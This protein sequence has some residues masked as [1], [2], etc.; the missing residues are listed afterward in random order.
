MKQNRTFTF[1]DFRTV[2]SYAPLYRLQHLKYTLRK[3]FGKK[4]IYAFEQFVNA[5]PIRQGL[6][7]HCPQN[8]YPLLREFVDRRFNCKRRLDA[9]TADFLMA[10]KLFGTDILHQMEDYRFH[11]VLAHLSDG[12][13]LWLNRNDNCVE[14]GAWSLSL[15]DE[16]GNRLYM[17][18]FAFV[19][20]HLLT[21]SVQGP[22]GEEAK[23]T[24]RRITKQLHGLRPQQLMVTALQYFAAV[25]GLDGAMGIAQKHQVKLRWKLKKRV[26]MNYDAFWQEYG[27]SLERDGYWHLPQTPARKDLAD[28]ESKKRSMYRKRYEMLDNMVA[29]MK[30]SLKTEARGISDGIQT[31]KPPRRTA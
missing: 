8:A 7:L 27:S 12:I 9:M 19:G 14:E 22:A 11:L 2:Y 31:E 20:T 4:E 21:A 3:F 24:V 1:P 28:I 17:A 18:T 5:S 6:F 15:R 23:D 10:E 26:K 16:A 25:L 30:D 29:E 13:S